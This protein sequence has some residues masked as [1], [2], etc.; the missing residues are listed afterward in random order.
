MHYLSE[1]ESNVAGP[2]HLESAPVRPH[3]D[4]RRV[5]SI[6]NQYLPT[7]L[8]HK[9]LFFPLS[10]THVQIVEHSSRVHGCFVYLKLDQYR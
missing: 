10:Q 7:A 8:S 9:Q 5:E 4:D 3:V 2:A 1:I 6:V